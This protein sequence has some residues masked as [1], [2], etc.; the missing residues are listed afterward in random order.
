M[1]QKSREEFEVEANRDMEEAI[2][3]SVAQNDKDLLQAFSKS[4]NS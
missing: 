4:V 2:K 1:I 3:A